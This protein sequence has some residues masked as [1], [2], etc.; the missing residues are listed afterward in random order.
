MPTINELPW[1]VVTPAKPK[2]RNADALTSVFGMGK[3]AL[4]CMVPTFMHSIL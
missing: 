3:G 2:L 4:C 1:T